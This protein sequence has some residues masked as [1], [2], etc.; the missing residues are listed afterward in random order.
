MSPLKKKGVDMSALVPYTARITIRNEIKWTSV[1]YKNLTIVISSGTGESTK[2]V[3]FNFDPLS[4]AFHG[5]DN[6]MLTVSTLLDSFPEKIRPPV[7]T[8]A[9]HVEQ[10]IQHNAA[11]YISSSFTYTV[12]VGN[13]YAGSDGVLHFVQ[14]MEANSFLDTFK[15]TSKKFAEAATSASSAIN[16]FGDLYIAPAKEFNGTSYSFA[17]SADGSV[18]VKSRTLPGMAALV[19]CPCEFPTHEDEA[20]IIIQHL[21]DNIG[22]SREKIADWLDEL[23][24]SGQINIEFQPWNEGEENEDTREG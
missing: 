24:D 19:T 9:E 13:I 4:P 5:G 12:S 6:I 15:A 16:E 17:P 14:G 11:D 18:T 7:Q 2:A 22:W 3:K 8:V 10:L 20:W 23:H 21:N 1:L